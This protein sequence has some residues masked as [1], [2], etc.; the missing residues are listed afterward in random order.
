MT[1]KTIPDLPAAALPLAGAELVHI[2]Q[3]GHS[4]QATVDNLVDGLALRIIPFF[5]TTPPIASEVLAIYAAVDAFTLP[6]NLAGSR[7]VVGTNPTATFAIDVQRQ[8][9]GAGAFATIAT[10][11][12]SVGG[13]P[14][15]TTAGGTA[16]AIG[17][18]DV[19]KFVAPAVTDA[20]IANVAINAKGT[21]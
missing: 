9:A 5:F 21:L 12:I 17:A 14:T 13:V 10:I 20:T 3:G 11:S 4:R 6:A 18:T 19:I 2:I 8:V 1:S 7:V 15:L 16:K